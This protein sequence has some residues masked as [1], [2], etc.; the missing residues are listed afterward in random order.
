MKIGVIGT[1]QFAGSFIHLWQL[2][3]DVEA[4]YVTDL[5][6]ERAA[7]HVA[8]YG[9]AAA[10]DTVDELLASDC[11]AVAVFTQRWTH[12]EL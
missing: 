8:R 1:G 5:V 10:Y 9:V 4:V 2:H 3:P 11:D 6:P 12:A 7:E